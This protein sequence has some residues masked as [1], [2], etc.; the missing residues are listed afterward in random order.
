MPPVSSITSVLSPSCLLSLA[1]VLVGKV[2]CSLMISHLLP[3]PT[4][5]PVCCP[6][7]IAGLVPSHHYTIIP[8]MSAVHKQPFP[9]IQSRLLLDP[10]TIIGPEDDSA[11]QTCPDGPRQDEPSLDTNHIIPAQEHRNT[12]INTVHRRLPAHHF[13]PTR[14]F[15]PRLTEDVSQHI[16]ANGGQSKPA[17]PS[18]L[19]VSTDERRFIC[20]LS[21]W[22]HTSATG[23]QPSISSSLHRLTNVQE[24]LL[25]V[26]GGGRGDWM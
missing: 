3:T 16:T 4:Q 9:E 14:C 2:S 20:V 26:W 22:F 25:H 5:Q 17:F 10:R 23:L 18:L 8:N 13:L 21:G 1:D 6:L 7:L 24:L 11:C 15:P 12:A 19:S